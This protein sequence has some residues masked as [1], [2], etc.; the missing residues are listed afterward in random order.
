MWRVKQCGARLLLYC[1]VVGSGHTFMIS[2]VAHH[3]LSTVGTCCAQACAQGDR[4]QF[5][6]G[7]R[8]GGLP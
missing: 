6:E 4:M 7:K 1:A 8:E 5:W 3:V 2:I